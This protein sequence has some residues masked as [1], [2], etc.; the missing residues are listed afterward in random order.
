MK[1]F[2]ALFISKF[3]LWIN[4]LIGNGQSDRAGLLAA[5]ICP[6][7]LTK[8]NKPKLVIM[9]TGTNGKTTVSHLIYDVLK[10]DGKKIGFNTWNANMRAGHIRCLIDSVSIFN[11]P[12]KDCAILEC[13][14]VT[15][16]LTVPEIKPNYLIVT[17]ICRDSIRRNSYPEYIF[18]KINDATNKSTSTKLILNADDP[19]SSLLGRNNEKI[20][21]SMDKFDNSEVY[22]NISPDFITCPRCNSIV[23][24]EY[25]HYRHIGKYKCPSCGLE[26]I[27]GDYIIN[28]ILENDILINGEKYKKLSNNLFNAYNETMAIVLLKDLGYS[29]DYIKESLEKIEIPKSR[30][31]LE[32][33]NGIKIYSQMAKGQNSSALSTVLESLSKLDNKKQI[34]LLLDEVYGTLDAE[35]T[36]TWLY[37]SD[38]ELLNKLNLEQIIVTGPRYLDYIVRLKLAGIDE[39]KIKAVEDYRH[40]HRKVKLDGKS[41]IYV[42]YEVDRR[43]MSREVIDLLKQR[44]MYEVK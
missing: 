25:K 42:L 35:E 16:N 10:L 23:K 38:F 15:S 26:S 37:D 28:N 8:I 6:E 36:I 27:K 3:Y 30:E 12:N 33:Q 39:S 34:I 31:N 1:L 22:E 5:K 19:I 4:K 20:Y 41:D 43:P 18:S 9:V 17:N 14:E 44:I 13:D 32:I 2:F 21:I 29:D 11:K 24:Y 40:A 7:I